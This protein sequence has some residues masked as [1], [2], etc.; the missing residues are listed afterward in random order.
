[1][2]KE[3]GTGVRNMARSH[4]TGREIHGMCANGGE[5][6]KMCANGHESISQK[7][8]S[9]AGTNVKSSNTK[10]T[11][12]DILSMLR[13]NIEND[14]YSLTDEQHARLTDLLLDEDQDKTD[15]DYAGELTKLLMLAGFDKNTVDQ[16]VHQN[17]Y[18]DTVFMPDNYVQKVEQQKVEQR[19]KPVW[20][21]RCYIMNRHTR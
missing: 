14:K 12:T 6:N 18:S 16:F 4:V 11:L 13:N 17:N 2:A 21:N 20:Y 7:K 5:I 3:D 19:K 15:P 1:M 10:I 9:H 8:V